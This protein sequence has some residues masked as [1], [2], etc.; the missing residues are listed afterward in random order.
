MKAKSCPLTSLSLY[1]LMLLGFPSAY[2]YDVESHCKA[3]T[4]SKEAS[5]EGLLDMR[6]VLDTL[7]T[8]IQQHHSSCIKEVSLP[9]Q[10]SWYKKGISLKA[11]QKQ[12]TTYNEIRNIKPVVRATHFHLTSV[13][14][15]W[16]RKMKFVK[17]IGKHLFYLERQ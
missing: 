2:A 9:G 15:K 11:T 3:I 4:I 17:K 12:L 13:H 8:R 5:G 6:A 14:P 1:L 7:E 10:W 16:V